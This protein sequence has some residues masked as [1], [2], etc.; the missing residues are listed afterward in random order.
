MKAANTW[1]SYNGTGPVPNQCHRGWAHLRNYTAQYAVWGEG[2]PLLVVPGL[3]GGMTLLGPMI[4]ALSRHYQVI[5]FQLRGE[6]NF[7]AL[8]GRGSLSGLVD[9]LDEFLS[10]LGLE[11]PSV[12]GVSFGG[13][14]ALELARRSPW[15][16]GALM[17]QGVAARLEPGALQRLAG[18]VLARYPLPADS[19][20]FNQF[21]NLFFGGKQPP[22]KLFDFVTRTCW[23]TDQ[24]VMAH[25]F[26]LIET[27]DF[28]GHLQSV[29]TPTLLMA[30]SRDLLVTPRGLATLAQELPEARAVQ[31][32][33]CGHLAA[34]THPERVALEVRSFLRGLET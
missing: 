32:G 1:L 28:T 20:F 2:P 24:G 7:F 23:T 17:L 9:D 16:L 19:P 26:R 11:Q 4:D 33:E 10:W 27:T 5:S 3:A 31:L 14:L 8:R 18:T 12:L 21:F 13:V 34:V 6:D 30:G 15:R 22:G 29:I 25:R